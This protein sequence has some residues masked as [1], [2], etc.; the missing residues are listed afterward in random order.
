MDKIEGHHIAL[1]L[2]A[3]IYCVFSFLQLSEENKHKENMAKIQ[4]G[5]TNTVK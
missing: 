4:A 3:I 5:V 1:I 2:I